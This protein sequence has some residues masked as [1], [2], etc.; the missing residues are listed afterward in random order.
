MSPRE[1]DLPLRVL[2]TE[3]PDS[4]TFY[5]PIPIQK[6]RIR[7][8]LKTLSAQ[9]S[10]TVAPLFSPTPAKSPPAA[11]PRST[12]SML[13]P[14]SSDSSYSSLAQNI[15]SSPAY[16]QQSCSDQATTYLANNMSSMFQSLKPRNKGWEDFKHS[17]KRSSTTTAPLP[18]P[19]IQHFTLPRIKTPPPPPL[20]RRSFLQLSRK[21]PLVGDSQAMPS[22][23]PYSTLAFK[24]NVAHNSSTSFEGPK[25]SLFAKVYG[26]SSEQESS[27]KK[28][29]VASTLGYRGSVEAKREKSSK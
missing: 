27:T 15:P 7:P 21:T 5:A 28:I 10:C 20:E 19:T 2:R 1:P 8:V 18:T 16:G 13:F 22:Q 6:P 11:K 9:K 25:M 17:S 23:N 29:G 24:T 12:G 4:V 26:M 14:T 3:T